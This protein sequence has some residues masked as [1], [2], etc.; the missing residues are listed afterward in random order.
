MFGCS[1]RDDL[2][3]EVGIIRQPV[4]FIVLPRGDRRLRLRDGSETAVDL[5]FRLRCGHREW[6]G[7][8]KDPLDPRHLSE[9]EQGDTKDPPSHLAFFNCCSSRSLARVSIFFQT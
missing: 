6:L 9:P 8:V 3:K 4:L 2:Q 5:E 7:G 1:M